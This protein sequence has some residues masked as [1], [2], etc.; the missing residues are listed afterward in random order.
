MSDEIVSVAG[1]AGVL[2]AAPAPPVTV[3]FTPKVQPDKPAFP[4][5]VK[6]AVFG[7]AATYCVGVPY[8][9]YK[10]MQLIISLI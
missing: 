7:G 10:L 6:Y 8:L 4:K 1:A 2:P 9:I 5:W 3:G